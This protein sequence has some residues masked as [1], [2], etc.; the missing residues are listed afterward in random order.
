MSQDKFE[1][2]L[3]ELENF[4]S[5]SSEGLVEK[6][7]AVAAAE[8][9]SI[10]L[11]NPRL[12]DPVFKL[13]ADPV[14]PK[15]RKKDR[16]KLQLQSPHRVHFYWSVKSNPFKSLSK[17]IGDQ[18]G[19][20]TLVVRFINLSSGEEEIYRVESKGDWWFDVRPNNTYRAE[21][22]F[23]APNR[24]FI[25][26][27]YSNELTTPRKSPSPR[28]DYT[29]GFTT[30]SDEFSRTLDAAGYKKDAFDV[31]LTGDE[32]TLARKATES[33][34]TELAGKEGFEFA[35][36]VAA[37]IRFALLALSSGHSLDELSGRVREEV[38]RLIEEHIDALDR[39][40]ILASLGTSFD[41]VLENVE[42]FEEI[43]EA[44]FGL[45]V[46]NFPRRFRAKQVP[47]SL[48]PKLSDYGNPELTSS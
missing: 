35:D 14:L 2:D 21:I 23:Y 3:P 1:L 27:L 11:S 30:T 25:R 17:T 47:R 8:A 26:I 13:L 28:T 6:R 18:F 45:S 38:I 32:P 19:S 42:E 37:E 33:V 24:P 44:V 48:L 41:L 20:Y 4:E 36:D 12:K 15:L 34:F 22:G 40:A 10:P 5:K 31:A 39:E 29:T 7:P 9:I 46:V 16:A 43:G